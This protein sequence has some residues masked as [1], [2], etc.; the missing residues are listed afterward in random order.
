M[1]HLKSYQRFLLLESI[2]TSRSFLTGLEETVNGAISSGVDATAATD[3]IRDYINKNKEEINSNL[4]DTVFVKNLLTILK[5]WHETYSDDLARTE[6]A[7]L[8]SD[9]INTDDFDQEELDYEAPESGYDD[10]D[11]IEF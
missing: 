4:G 6:L 2:E 8:A 7:D 5:P 3:S 1:K 9:G 11:D 10:D